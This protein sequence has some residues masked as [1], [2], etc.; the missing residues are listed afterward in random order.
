[1][2]IRKLLCA[3]TTPRSRKNEK[4][5]IDRGRKSIGLQ[6]KSTRVKN[7]VVRR[8]PKLK[9]NKKRNGY[10]VGSAVTFGGSVS[11]K[12]DFEYTQSPTL[13]KVDSTVSHLT[14]SG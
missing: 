5:L 3:V 4:P 7:N 2:L 8:R 1:M 10:Y 12:R 9:K 11:K 13:T 14:Y 6:R